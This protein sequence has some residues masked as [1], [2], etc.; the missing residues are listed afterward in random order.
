M[1]NEIEFVEYGKFFNED[2]A[3][4]FQILDRSSDKILDIAGRRRCENFIDRALR[5]PEPGSKST[6][7]KK[8]PNHGTA[9]L[10]LDDEHF[11]FV[12]IQRREEGEYAK[13]IGNTPILNRPYN[14]VRFSLIEKNQADYYISHGFPLFLACFI[15]ILLKTILENTHT[16]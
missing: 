15:K 2:G 13:S 8:V 7:T 6:F 9:F 4:D 14:Q 5:F 11:L 3:S 10:N 12:Q 16:L 1:N